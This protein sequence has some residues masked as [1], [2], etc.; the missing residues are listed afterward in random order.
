MKKIHKTSE[1]KG[2][3]Y[4]ANIKQKKDGT[5]TLK[6]GIFFTDPDIGTKGEVEIRPSRDSVGS[7]HTHPGSQHATLSFGDLCEYAVEGNL[8]IWCVSGSYPFDGVG[9]YKLKLL[10]DGKLPDMTKKILKY[11]GGKQESKGEDLY[12]T[13]Y[14][15]KIWDTV[16]FDGKPA[17]E[18]LDFKYDKKTKI[19]TSIPTGIKLLKINDKPQCFDTMTKAKTKFKKYKK[20][21]I[22]YTMAIPVI[23]KHCIY[24]EKRG[25]DETKE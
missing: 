8:D 6:Q 16:A 14:N 23:D 20:D 12:F 9:C 24:L 1:R 17:D 2:V 22:C 10:K 13:V 15:D 18:A 19:E 4:G 3:E 25:K 7:F 5:L 21:N 11:C